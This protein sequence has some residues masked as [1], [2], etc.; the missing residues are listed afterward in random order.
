M[1]ALTPAI[2]LDGCRISRP[3]SHIEI[4][5][6]D[7]R[8]RAFPTRTSN[9]L[10]ICLKYGGSHHV[11]ADGRSRTYP[12]DALCIRP[13]GCVW[14][15]EPATAGFLSL[16]I[17]TDWLPDEGV[18]G[19]M[20]FGAARRLPE[21]HRIVHRLQ[22]PTSVLEAEVLVADL[23][24]AMK[25]AGALELVALHDDGAGAPGTRRARE[26]LHTHA[27]DIATLD[28][29]AQHAG[30]NKFV[31]VRWFRRLFGTTP[32]AYLMAVR[33][34]RARSRLAAGMSVAESSLLTGF[35]DQAHLSRWFKRLHGITP[36]EY[37]RQTRHATRSISFK[38]PRARRR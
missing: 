29:V 11:R 14:S 38:T 2:A 19:T 31:L 35:A 12:A 28:E 26:F 37:A 32:H 20:T 33:V 17:A 36:T 27:G 5:R 22:Q 34:D 23:V 1:P 16:D 10:G 24:T 15:S 13:P 8:L 7:P 21:F 25:D 3:A 6:A 9:T 30:M 18:T 4:V